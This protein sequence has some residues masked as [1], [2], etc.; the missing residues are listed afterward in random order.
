MLEGEDNEHPEYVKTFAKTT[1][2]ASAFR[3]ETSILY[4]LRDA[5]VIVDAKFREQQ[6]VALPKDAKVLSATIAGSYVLIEREEA[7]ALL[8]RDD[9]VQLGSMTLPGEVSVRAKATRAYLS[10]SPTL[11]IV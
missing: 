1:L 3:N 10:G 8:F 6:R 5:I 4:L 7:P 2:S 9:G 11:D